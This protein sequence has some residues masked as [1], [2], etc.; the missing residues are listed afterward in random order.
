MGRT[1]RAIAIVAFTLVSCS[2]QAIPASTPTTDAAILRLYTTTATVRLASDLTYEYAQ[3]RP[4]VSFDIIESNYAGITDHVRVETSAYF[5]TSHLPHTGDFPLWAA[6][7]GQDGIAIITHRDNPVRNLTT[8][9]LRDIYQGQ[10]TNWQALGGNDQPIQVFSREEGSGTRAE[11]EQLVMGDRQTIRSAM[12]APS[13]ETMLLSVLRSD[14]SIGYVSMSHLDASVQV[15]AVNDTQ[16]TGD[17]V[18]DNTYPLRSTLFIAGMQEPQDAEYRAFIGWVQS[19][20]GQA[21]VQRWHA[22]LLRPEP[23]TETAD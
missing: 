21:I 14:N 18:Y 7:V 8:A 1:R 6:P 5:L 20:A 10:I 15:L 23:L 11:F 3:L 16:I 13:S 12:I 4:S 9:Q 19:P 17:S 2:N 22:P